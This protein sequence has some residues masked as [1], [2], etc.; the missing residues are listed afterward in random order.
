MKMT[1]DLD[2]KNTPESKSSQHIPH[3]NQK[4]TGSTST[5]EEEERNTSETTTTD[6]PSFLQLTEEELN[7]NYFYCPNLF[8]NSILYFFF[9]FGN[10]Q[11]N[12]LTELC[13]YSFAQF[14]C[15][16]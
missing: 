5:K 6:I 9:L 2:E 12:S 3:S 11:T 1:S 16:R 8:I 13:A 15:S 4:D 14:H 7:V 10:H